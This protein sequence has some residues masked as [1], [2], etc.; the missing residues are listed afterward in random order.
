PFPYDDPN[1][2]ISSIDGRTGKT[3]INWDVVLKEPGERHIICAYNT[4]SY[5]PMSY[6]PGKNSLYIPYA[7][8]CLDMTR[9]APAPAAAEAPAQTDAAG[10]GRGGG[11]RGA[12]D[13]GQPE[14]RQGVRRPGSDPEK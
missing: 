14:R 5:W 6:H 12:N 13:G 1:F 7:D 10:A 8:D 3:T 2:L 4:K 11:G 9:A